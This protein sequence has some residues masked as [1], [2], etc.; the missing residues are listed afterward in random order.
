MNDKIEFLFV[1]TN[2]ILS[3]VGLV[4]LVYYILASIFGWYIP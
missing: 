1:W 4:L 3:L 2:G